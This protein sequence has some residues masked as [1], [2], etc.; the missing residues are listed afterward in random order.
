MRDWIRRWGPAVAVAL[1]LMGLGLLFVAA[2]RSGEDATPGI[3]PTATEGMVSPL[4]V[5]PLA[6]SPFS[7]PGRPAP[8][9]HE[10]RGMPYTI[11]QNCPVMPSCEDAANLGAAW[12]FQ[13]SPNAPNCKKIE[14]V[15][16]IWGVRTVGRRCPQVTGSSKVLLTFNEPD[17]ADQANIPPAAGAVAFRQV[18]NCYPDHLLVAPSILHDLGWLEKMRRI[19]IELYG[20]PPRFDFLSIHCYPVG[21]PV[22][23]TCFAR[24][25]RAKALLDLWHVE[26]GIIIN[27]WSPWRDGPEGLAEMRTMLLRFDSDPDVTWHAFNHPRYR[28]DEWWAPR[29]RAVTALFECDSRELTAFGKLYRDFEVHQ[30]FIPAVART[31]RQ[32]AATGTRP[33]V[34]RR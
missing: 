7:P 3:A 11:V 17:A 14:S 5:S 1:A 25:D 9:L 32:V 34:R 30:V 33:G 22:V 4:A 19:Y 21:G 10:K 26:G 15:G 6:V 20:A 24:L 23:A 29:S 31:A 27:E 8:A 12:V 13:W 18:E 28:G 16:M 2:P